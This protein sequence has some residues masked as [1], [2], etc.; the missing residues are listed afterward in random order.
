[1]ATAWTR[2]R[3]SGLGSDGDKWRLQVLGGIPGRASMMIA[4]KARDES[5]LSV[6]A[7]VRQAARRPGE[8]V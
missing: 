6:P 5:V 1:M 7:A 3:A 8:A 2:R 4:P